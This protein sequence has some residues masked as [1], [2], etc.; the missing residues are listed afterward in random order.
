MN[1]QQRERHINFMNYI[2]EGPKKYLVTDPCYLLK[3]YEDEWHD[4]LARIDRPVWKRH[5]TVDYDAPKPKAGERWTWKRSATSTYIMSL[6]PLPYVT[7]PYTLLAVA[8]VPMGDIGYTYEDQCIGF[9][10]GT[11]CI[12][13]VAEDFEVS[14]NMN[15]V[16]GIFDGFEIAE[17]AM[18]MAIAYEHLEY[19]EDEIF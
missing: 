2:K 14:E 4:M 5:G 6:W 10:S 7:G 15:H 16:M 13:E 3:E 18:N 17:Q 9:D 19:N 11:V 12:A 1:E 8:A